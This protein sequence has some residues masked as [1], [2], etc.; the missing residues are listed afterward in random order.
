[1]P[2]AGRKLNKAEIIE[3]IYERVGKTR[4][5]QI[6]RV[7]DVFFE[8]IIKGIEADKIIELRGLGTFEVKLRRAKKTVRNPRTGEK[9]SGK[10]HG[11]VVFRPGREL[12]R[13]A[14]PM[15]D[16]DSGADIT[17]RETI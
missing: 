8:Q 10:D 5:N 3:E 7:L 1:M 6:R 14:W 2:V 12:K 13:I 17:P 15:R 16:D 4:R 11:V 9:Y